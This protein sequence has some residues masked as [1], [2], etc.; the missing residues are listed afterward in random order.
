VITDYKLRIMLILL[1]PVVGAADTQT[2]MT[3]LRNG[4]VL[5]SAIRL[6]KADISG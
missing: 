4:G 2:D 3:A 1:I 6:G 5:M